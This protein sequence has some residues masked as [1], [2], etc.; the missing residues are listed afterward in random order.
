MLITRYH[1][2]IERLD[3]DGLIIVTF[4]LI[5]QN[6]LRSDYLVDLYATYLYYLKRSR[7]KC[8]VGLKIIMRPF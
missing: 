3:L 6:N 1:R 5:Q 8:F 7:L 4:L 2:A